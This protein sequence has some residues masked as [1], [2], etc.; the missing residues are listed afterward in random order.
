[1]PY[2]AGTVTLT[3]LAVMLRGLVILDAMTIKNNLQVRRTNNRVIEPKT[4]EQ[5]RDR[6]SAETRHAGFIITVVYLPV[7]GAEQTTRLKHSSGFAADTTD[8]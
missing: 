7:M 1:M 2:K 8:D 6:L 3:T 4:R 5:G